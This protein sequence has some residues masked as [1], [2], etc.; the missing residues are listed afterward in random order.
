MYML[1]GFV[2]HSKVAKLSP[3]DILVKS[4]SGFLKVPQSGPLKAKTPAI[5]ESYGSCL[6]DPHERAGGSRKQETRRQTHE[7]CKSP[8]TLPLRSLVSGSSH[9]LKNSFRS[10]HFAS[11]HEQPCSRAAYDTSKERKQNRAG[12]P[13]CLKRQKRRHR[14]SALTGTTQYIR[15][16]RLVWVIM[17]FNEHAGRL[18][19]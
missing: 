6:C 11:T 12:N 7:L 17:V 15:R 14:T 19:C 3:S 8:D 2:S 5:V 13:S 16:E 1:F 4:V 10:T 9:P 18:M